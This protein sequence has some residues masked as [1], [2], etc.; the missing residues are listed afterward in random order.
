M[1]MSIL[2]LKMY[3]YSDT[4]QIRKSS[5]IIWKQL[6]RGIHLWWP[7]H[8]NRINVCF[9]F[10][11]CKSC[12]FW[13]FVLSISLHVSV[14]LICVLKENFFTLEKWIGE[15]LFSL[16]FTIVQKSHTMAI[17]QKNSLANVRN[18]IKGVSTS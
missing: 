9:Q 7:K 16:H 13:S 17:C 3:R 4:I 11:D 10:V 6:K 1:S 2:L 8:R 5:K 12:G 14:A 18:L 15:N